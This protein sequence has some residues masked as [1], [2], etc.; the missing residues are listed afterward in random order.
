MK[1]I[2]F[3]IGGMTRGGAERV[4]SIL[5]NQYAKDGKDLEFNKRGKLVSFEEGPFYIMVSKPAIH[6]TMGGVKINTSAQV[7]NEDG[8]IIEGLFAAGEVVGDIHGVNRL[9]SDAITDITVFGRI[10]GES[11]SK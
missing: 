6:H 5:A 7:V 9:G 2:S 11:A 3:V 1:K 8:S 10:A 4:I